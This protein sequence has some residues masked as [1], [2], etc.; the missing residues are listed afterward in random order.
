MFYGGYMLRITVYAK[1]WISLLTVFCFAAQLA[2]PLV[3]NAA[4]S[5]PKTKLDQ[6]LDL[7]VLAH[8]NDSVHNLVQKT[9]EKLSEIPGNNIKLKTW[10]ADRHYRV[11][12]NIEGY[13]TIKFPQ[14]AS[15]QIDRF[16]QAAGTCLSTNGPISF[17]F[18]VKDFSQ[19]AQDKWKLCFQMDMVFTLKEVVRHVIMTG[20]S[21]AGGV[22]I[23]SGIAKATSFVDSVNTQRLAIALGEGIKKLW[24]LGAGKIAV[25]TY[26]SMS[27]TGRFKLKNVLTTVFTVKSLLYH[28][29]AFI[30]QAG[31]T[32]G[33]NFTK[34]TLGAAIGTS[35]ATQAGAFIGAAV[36]A[37]A[38]TLI[39][40]YIIDKLTVDLPII[41]RMRKIRKLK[42][43]IDI[44]EQNEELQNKLLSELN[45][46]EEKTVLFLKEEI[47]LD[48]YSTF[49][50]FIK[51]LKVAKKQGKLQYY[52]GLIT[53]AKAQ[54]S[55]S[56]I[57]DENWNAARYYYQLLEAIGEFPADQRTPESD[58]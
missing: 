52:R 37:A 54:L 50:I 47:L 51:K 20:L 32:A 41:L 56:A 3:C 9:C 19:T 16:R 10:L 11:F 1:K 33:A 14:F 17:D 53:K 8:L 40:S 49:E 24:A 7:K 6:R 5:Q 38:I 39:G 35:L 25:N 31:V 15:S 26:E 43:K 4:T 12:A 30:L 28:F 42:D 34:L 45:D 46:T 21:I 29:G 44:A 18:T 13:V 23:G 36:A 48:R 2:F 55:T 27:V 22:A 57:Y 58:N